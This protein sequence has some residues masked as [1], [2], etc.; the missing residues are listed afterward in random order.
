MTDLVF[1]AGTYD[2]R[3]DGVSDYTR[4]LR[5]SLASEGVPSVVVTTHRAA[6]E[7]DEAAV[8][9]AVGSWGPSDLPRLVTR[10]RRLDPRVLHVQ[11]AAGTYRFRRS[12]FL[13]PPLLRAA[14]WRGRLV[15]TLHEYGWWEWNR[16]PARAK[17]CVDGL[18]DWGQRHGWWD[19]EDLFLTTGSDALV[20][21][22]PLAAEVLCRRLPGIRPR[23]TH[24]PIAPNVPVVEI[25]REEARARLMAETGW[26]PDDVVIAFFGFLHPVKG[27]DRLLEAFAAVRERSTRAR[28]LLIGGVTS[29][30]LPQGEAERYE[31]EI[32]TRTAE[33][34]I[35]EHVHRTGYRPDEDVS[36]LLAAADVGALPFGQGL[37]TKSG[38]L[39]TLLQH[40]LPV[41]GTRADTPDPLLEDQR[42]VTLVPAG[43]TGALADALGR[44][45][46]DDQDR[47][48]S[49]GSAEC[50]GM[51]FSWK[52]IVHRHLTLYDRLGLPVR[53]AAE[54]DGRP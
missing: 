39:L 38:A 8:L 46:G 52:E 25:A 43:D 26:G 22:N 16:V 42:G 45:V 40:G 7:T 3:H 9:G 37:T 35:R 18:A 48:T 41:V 28:L 23:V 12:V 27:I 29:L 10:L 49:A 19:V 36:T 50:L 1:V 20:V 32:S 33:L 4:R 11:H 31:E 34:G 2:P 44:W 54:T 53:P 47:V 5:R 17:P 15:T 13:L 51:R 21:S 30:A 24:V 14:G 6:A